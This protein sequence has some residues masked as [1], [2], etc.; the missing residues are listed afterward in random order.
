MN[1]IDI[2]GT[3]GTKFYR[4][5]VGK[6]AEHP[7]IAKAT[8]EK[9]DN[10]DYLVVATGLDIADEEIHFTLSFS[11]V[12]RDR[13]DITLTAHSSLLNINTTW[14][15]NPWTFDERIAADQIGMLLPTIV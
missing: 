1:L 8:V 12:T 13:A 3:K 4:A 5:I 9:N 15:I 10:G 14:D 11:D 7:S 2:R 6:L